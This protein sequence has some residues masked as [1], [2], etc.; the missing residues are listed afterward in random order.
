[1]TDALP[2]PDWVPLAAKMA[3]LAVVV[4]AFQVVGALASIGF[5]LVKGFT[6]IEPGLYATEVLLGSVPFVLM[7]GL[8]LVL[9]VLSNNK[10]IGYGLLIGW[11]VVQ[12]TLGFLDFDHNL[13]SYGSA[14][15]A[16]Y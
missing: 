4:L 11:L 12:A 1:M 5:Q 9:Q 3:C 16:P 7:G 13:Y 6:A 10:F 2:V 8:A 15:A 14:P